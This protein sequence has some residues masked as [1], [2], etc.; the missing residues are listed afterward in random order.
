MPEALRVRP[1]TVEDQQD[2]IDEDQAQ[3]REVEGCREDNVCD[4]GP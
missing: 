3:D 1:W 4:L 2:G